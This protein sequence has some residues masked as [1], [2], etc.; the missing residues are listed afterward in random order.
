MNLLKKL[1]L[2]SCFVASLPAFAESKIGVVDIRAALFSSDAAKEFSQR[3]S[4]EFKTQEMEVRSVQ[5]S[6]HKLQERLKKDAAIMSDTERTQIAAQLEE[7]AQ[8]FKYLKGKL[9]S[10]VASKKQAFLQQSKPKVDIVLK[11]LVEADKY[12]LIFPRESVIYSVQ[13]LDITGKV[14]ERLNALK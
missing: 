1:V 3:L 13:T 8:E 12:D 10:A 5:E 4:A 2:V 7:K 9:D 6:G 14:I 11:E